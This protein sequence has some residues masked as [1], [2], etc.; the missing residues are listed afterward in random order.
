MNA[1][2]KKQPKRKEFKVFD[3]KKV[4]KVLKM[5]QQE[6]WHKVHVT[7]SGGSRYEDGREMP[8]CVNI[9]LHLVYGKDPVKTLA[10][11]RGQSRLDLLNG[12]PS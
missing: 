7:Q 1:N 11:L 3:A 6:F 9:C 12:Y 5:N 4:R 8:D 10:D 2:T